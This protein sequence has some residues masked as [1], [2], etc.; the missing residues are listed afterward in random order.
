MRVSETTETLT[1]SWGFVDS[2][3]HYI[4]SCGEY[5]VRVKETSMT[6]LKNM[7]T[8]NSIAVSVVN[9]CGLQSAPAIHYLAQSTTATNGRELFFPLKIIVLLLCLKI[10]CR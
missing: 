10:Q 4:V 9:H 3:D 2:A 7:C 1:I 8:N 5:R 6:M